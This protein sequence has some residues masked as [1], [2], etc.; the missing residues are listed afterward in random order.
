[1]FLNNPDSP[2][3]IITTRVIL[4]HN[5]CSCMVSYTVSSDT[6]VNGKQLGYFWSQTGGT[7]DGS[8]YGQ[9]VWVA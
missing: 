8:Q 2:S 5:S 7:I 9:V 4:L 6:T 1:M 3:V